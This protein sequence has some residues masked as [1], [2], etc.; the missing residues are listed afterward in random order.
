MTNALCEPGQDSWGCAMTVFTGA[1]NFLD[2]QLITTKYPKTQLL[3][4]LKFLN[5]PDILFE[6]AEKDILLYYDKAAEPLE[7]IAD[8]WRSTIPIPQH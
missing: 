6:S 3:N 7:Q 1:P 8:K 5:L 2:P 4:L